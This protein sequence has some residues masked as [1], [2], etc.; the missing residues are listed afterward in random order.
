[1]PNIDPVKSIFSGE[2]NYAVKP[3][4][5]INP[6]FFEAWSLDLNSKFQNLLTTDDNDVPTKLHDIALK[7]DQELTRLRDIR[8]NE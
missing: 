1:L 5:Y 6:L 2:I 4:G 3:T 7:L 8:D